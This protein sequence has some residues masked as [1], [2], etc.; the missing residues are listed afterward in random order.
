MRS[1]SSCLELTAGPEEMVQ[2]ASRLAYTLRLKVEQMCAYER[3]VVR[4]DPDARF[5][6]AACKT[7]GNTQLQFARRSQLFPF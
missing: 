6:L 2:A 1:L 7:L 5:E 3:L 4:F